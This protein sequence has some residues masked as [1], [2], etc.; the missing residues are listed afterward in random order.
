MININKAEKCFKNYGYADIIDRAQL[1]GPKYSTINIW[2]NEVIWLD[3]SNPDKVIQK[4]YKLKGYY[5]DAEIGENDAYI[6]AVEERLINSLAAKIVKCLAEL[7][8]E[9]NFLT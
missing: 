8:T 6:G 3:I 2:G 7:P 5:V 4:R 1:L 9:R